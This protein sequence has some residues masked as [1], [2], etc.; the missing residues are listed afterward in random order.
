MPSS[1]WYREIASQAQ[2]EGIPLTEIERKELYFSKAAPETA[3]IHAEFERNYNRYDYEKKITALIRTARKRDLK[4]NE[5]NE[6]L[7]KK[8][9]QALSDGDQYLAE[10]VREAASSAHA[11]SST[12]PRC[13]VFQLLASAALATA[14]LALL[15]ML[16]FRALA[17]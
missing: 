12:H 4:A 15:L 7:W 5:E 14:L 3:E 10:L 17:H 8:A 13:Q 11:A 16:L 2:F 1:F 6:E 9:L